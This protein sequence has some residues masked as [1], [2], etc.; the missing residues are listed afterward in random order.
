[1]IRLEENEMHLKCDNYDFK[2]EWLKAINF[3]RDLYSNETFFHQRKY[4]EGLDDETSFRIF[5][6]NERK[7]WKLAKVDFQTFS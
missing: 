5:A 6:E 1:M 7:N 4:K 3:M 2:A